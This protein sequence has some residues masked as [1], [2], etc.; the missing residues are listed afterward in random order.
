MSSLLELVEVLPANNSDNEEL[1]EFLSDA[2]GIV[3]PDELRN[4]HGDPGCVIRY[5]S[6]RFGV[7]RLCTSDLVS[8]ADRGLFAHYLWN[9]A[10]LMAQLIAVGVP[11]F[12]NSGERGRRWSWSTLR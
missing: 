3:F 4:L 7:L 6:P 12:V 9:A 8:G 11:S 1:E 5:K 2:A 10:L